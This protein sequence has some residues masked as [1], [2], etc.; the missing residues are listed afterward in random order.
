[1]GV[2][3]WSGRLC[4]FRLWSAACFRV[5]CSSHWTACTRIERTILLAAGVP[6]PGSRPSICANRCSLTSTR[7]YD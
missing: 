3:V 6:P 1:M 5:K 4:W 2:S 7:S